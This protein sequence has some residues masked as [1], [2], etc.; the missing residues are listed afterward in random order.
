M[1]TESTIGS[2]HSLRSML[3]AATQVRICGLIISPITGANVA[4]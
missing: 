2:M 1:N 3:L 4:A